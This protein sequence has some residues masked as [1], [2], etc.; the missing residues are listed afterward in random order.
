MLATVDTNILRFIED[1]NALTLNG[2]KGEEYLISKT[3]VTLRATPS[4]LDYINAG[5]EM[6]LIGGI[7]FTASNGN[8][9]SKNSLHNWTDPQNQYIS[10][11]YE[12]SKILLN[13]DND[14]QIPLFG[15]GACL[16]KYSK[17]VSH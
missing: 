9:T 5:L 8:P 10:A 7:D 13:F 12:V 11:I 14:K 1:E 15:F 3:K 16:P 4:F 6:C 17:E 2:A